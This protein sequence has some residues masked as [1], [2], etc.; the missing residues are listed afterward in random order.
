MSKTFLQLSKFVASKSGTITG[1]F[2]LTVV[3]Q[4][5]RNKKVVD[6]TANA[7]RAIQTMHNNWIWMRK[8][9]VSALTIGNNQYAGVTLGL[10]GANALARWI[11]EPGTYTIYDPAIGVA[12]EAALT[13]VPWAEWRAKYYVGT[14]NNNRPQVYTISPQNELRVGPKPDKAYV[15]RGEYYQVVQDLTVDS[16]VPNLP[17][18]YHD[19]VAWRGLLLL[20]E[21]DEA[22][23]Q[24]GEANAEYG[25]LLS[26]LESTQL[27]TLSF[28]QEP[29]A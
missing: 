21:N 6:C 20:A 28:A 22:V 10:T 1:D 8:E 24:V 12:D 19:I 18:D 14:Q 5:S 9:I 15:F 25:R 2:P 27:P 29:L 23:G 13:K 17:S 11:T 7:W 3:S 4:T 16:D 26:A